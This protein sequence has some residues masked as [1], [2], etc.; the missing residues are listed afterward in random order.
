[1]NNG[2]SNTLSYYSTNGTGDRTHGKLQHIAIC[3]HEVSKTFAVSTD[4][5]PFWSQYITTYLM[6]L[7]NWTRAL[8]WGS[9]RDLISLIPRSLLLERRKK[10]C[11]H[12]QQ[13]A[14]QQNMLNLEKFGMRC[15]WGRKAVSGL[16]YQC[17]DQLHMTARQ[18]PSLIPDTLSLSPHLLDLNSATTHTN[19][20]YSVKGIRL[21]QN[22]AQN[23]LIAICYLQKA[24]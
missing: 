5:S 22:G 23:N 17:S 7:P 19:L 3:C 1:M 15:N 4:T 11:G 12:S 14:T 10:G 16:G 21:R 6:Y 9:M 18:P 8:D 24:R 13:S 2:D 20:G